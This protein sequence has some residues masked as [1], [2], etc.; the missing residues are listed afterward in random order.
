MAEDEV[1]GAGEV[2][3]LEERVRGLERLL[4]RKTMEAEILKEALAAA[5]AENRACPGRRPDGGSVQDFAH[6][7]GGGGW[8]GQA[9]LSLAW[10][11]GC[12]SR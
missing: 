4:G 9:V 12:M 2:R 7:A 10:C 3:Q 11:K 1:A 8:S 6:F 5:R